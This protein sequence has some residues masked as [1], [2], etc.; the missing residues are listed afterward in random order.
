MQLEMGIST[1][2]Y[3]PARGTAGLARSLVRGK[4][5]V[6]CPPPMM[7]ESTLLVLIDWRPDCGIGNLCLSV[8]TLYVYN[9]VRGQRASDIANG[10]DGTRRVQRRNRMRRLGTLDQSFRPLKRG[11]GRLSA[12]SLLLGMPKTAPI[13]QVNC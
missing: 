9:A 10:R 11:W 8:G 6:P 1:S 5:R 12:V 4:S 3:L 2:R 7:I 13:W